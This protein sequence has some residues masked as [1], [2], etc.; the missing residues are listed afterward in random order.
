MSSVGAV[1]MHQ[2]AQHFTDEMYEEIVFHIFHFFHNAPQ[3]ITQD[4]SV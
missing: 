4:T 2:D 3:F 1:Q